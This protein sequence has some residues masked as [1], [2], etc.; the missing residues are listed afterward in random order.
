M[1]VKI[2]YNIPVLLR[3]EYSIHFQSTPEAIFAHCKIHVWNK[4]VY[5]DIVPDIKK[6]ALKYV[7]PIYVV[8]NPKDNKFIKFVT[9][10][11]FIPTEVI[12]TEGLDIYMW[13]N[14]VK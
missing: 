7:K 14:H 4:K 13:S 3:K 6:L 12:T 9:H 10:V 5:K 8:V 1:H 11:G 2:V